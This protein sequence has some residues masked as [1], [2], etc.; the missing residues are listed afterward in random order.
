MP[1]ATEHSRQKKSTS[2]GTPLLKPAQYV[3]HNLGHLKR[4][5]Y[6]DI[7]VKETSKNVQNDLENV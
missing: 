7:A 6:P 4:D 1:L 5:L 3:W 2:R